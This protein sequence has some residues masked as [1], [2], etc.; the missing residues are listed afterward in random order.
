MA[1]GEPRLTLADLLPELGAIES[2][3]RCMEIAEEEIAAARGG[4][5]EA[6][7]DDPLWRSFTLLR[8]THEQMSTEF[9]YRAHCRELL[10]RVRR[11]A[12]TRPATDA[13]M[14]L[15]LMDVSL[16]TPMTGAATGLQFR[17]F[18]R[19]FPA[20][21]AS[22]FADGSANADD[23]EKLYGPAID[24]HE[25]FTRKKLAQDWRKL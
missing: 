21:Y 11:G 5:T 13:E 17:V 18:K 3:F 25:T 7:P 24:E 1:T 20:Q 2:V 16:V 22:L 14:A 12:D 15:A 10:E 9:V 8:T 4:R 23:Y 6:D 19:R